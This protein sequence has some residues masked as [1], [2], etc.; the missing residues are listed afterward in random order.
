LLISV[1]QGRA[2]GQSVTPRHETVAFRLW[3]SGCIDVG[4][5]LAL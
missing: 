3:H 2:F 5:G 1:R 4:G